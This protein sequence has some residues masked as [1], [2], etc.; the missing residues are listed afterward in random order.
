[1]QACNTKLA[2]SGEEYWQSLGR[3]PQGGGR[4]ESHHLDEVI[5]DTW[6]CH[7]GHVLPTTNVPPF[8]NPD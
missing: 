4:Q 7:V 3:G 2:S 6:T 5:L 1:M 8:K